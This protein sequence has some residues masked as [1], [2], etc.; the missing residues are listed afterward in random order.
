MRGPKKTGQFKK[1]YKRME[2]RHKDMSKIDAAITILINDGTLPPE[3]NEHKLSGDWDG[4]LECHIEP[5]WLMIY[6]YSDTRVTFERTGTHSD[7]F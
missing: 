6:A 2:K 7:L 1:D 5:D 4:W 3:Y